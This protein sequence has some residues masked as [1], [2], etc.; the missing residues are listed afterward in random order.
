MQWAQLS[1]HAF[2]S[3]DLKRA[4]IYNYSPVPGARGYFEQVY[5]FNRTAAEGQ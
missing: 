5:L 4:I 2:D 1:T 3:E